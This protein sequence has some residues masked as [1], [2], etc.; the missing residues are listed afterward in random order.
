M[1]ADVVRGH[2]RRTGR[3][4]GDGVPQRG[5][6]RSGCVRAPSKRDAADGARPRPHEERQR[7]AADQDCSRSEA[8][9]RRADARDSEDGGCDQKR[10]HR[11][12]AVVARVRHRAE[13]REAVGK[14]LRERDRG[15]PGRQ[16][17]EEQER[18]T[19][20]DQV[21]DVVPLHESPQ[22]R[23]GIREERAGHS[24][25]RAAHVVVEAEVGAVGAGIPRHHEVDRDERPGGAEQRD[26][27]TVAPLSVR[28]RVPDAERRDR[29]AHELS[30]GH[31][32]QRAQG[33][34]PQA[35]GVEKPDAEEVERDRERHGVDRRARARR[36]PRVRRDTQ[37]RAE[38]QH[39]RSRDAGD[40]ARRRAALPATRPR[41]ARTRAR[42]GSPRRARAAQAAT[43][44]G[45]TWAPSR[46]ICSPDTAS[47]T[48]SG[49]PCAVLHTACTMCPR[50]NRPSRKF[51]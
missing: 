13:V 8:A 6:V 26:R 19:E 11:S 40:R 44:N 18:K 23:A 43:R 48:S 4:E 10:D 50:S 25:G 39:S 38:R 42:A 33:E 9:A 15:K 3:D 37:A 49:L 17:E 31:R 5:D 41:S 45:S 46:T 21:R 14:K 32:D 2:H 27:G 28:E 51:V 47:V 29:Q 24:T 16:H 36:R 30:R 34:R 1:T 20:P 35:L 7:A 12:H 22:H